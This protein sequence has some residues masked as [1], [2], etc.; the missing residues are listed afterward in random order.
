MHVSGSNAL[1]N[2]Q[3]GMQL[4]LP[5]P[6]DAMCILFYFCYFA[7]LICI[8]IVSC[9]VSTNLWEKIIHRLLPLY[10]F[11]NIHVFDVHDTQ[12]IS[13]WHLSQTRRAHIQWFVKHDD[14]ANFHD[15]F[16]FVCASAGVG[17]CVWYVFTLYVAHITTF[18]FSFV[19]AAVSFSIHWH[20]SM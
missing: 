8:Y 12:S 1:I 2:D 6:N 16:S 10:F 14:F 15:N 13:W 11:K 20:S 5:F 4:P 18:C 3:Y 7:A 9:A 17:V 19:V